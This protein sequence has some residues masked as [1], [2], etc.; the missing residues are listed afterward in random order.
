MFAYCENNSVN[1]SDP[2]GHAGI[3]MMSGWDPQEF[4]KKRKSEESRYETVFAIGGGFGQG[5]YI[6][7]SFQVI[8]DNVEKETYIVTS[9]TLGGGVGLSAE[10]PAIQDLLSFP[11]LPEDKSDLLGIDGQWTLSM[12]GSAGPIGIEWDVDLESVDISVA[13]LGFDFHMGGNRWWVFKL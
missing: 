5:V 6:G 1:Y 11:I 4:H 9:L 2:M 7:S 3:G 13:K 8:R 10:V 12:G